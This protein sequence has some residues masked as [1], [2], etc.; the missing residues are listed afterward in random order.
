[1]YEGANSD[2][3]SPGAEERRKFPRIDIATNVSYAAIIPA[4]EVG[5]TKDISEGGMCLEMKRKMARGTILRLEFDLP[6]DKPE[7]IE[8]LGRIMWQRPKTEDTYATGIKFLT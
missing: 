2:P 1:M 6:G 3:A 8:A 5:T 4:Y 7:H